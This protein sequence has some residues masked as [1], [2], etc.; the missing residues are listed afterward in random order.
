MFLAGISDGRSGTETGGGW[1]RKAD[2]QQSDYAQS[3]KVGRC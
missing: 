2:S 3:G 1:P